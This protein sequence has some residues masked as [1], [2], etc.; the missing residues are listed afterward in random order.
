MTS[1]NKLTIVVGAG[2]SKEFGLP[3]G[4]ELK[5]KISSLLNIEFEDFGRQK[6]GDHEICEALRSVGA[7]RFNGQR[8][9][10]PFLES[11]RHIRDAMPQALSIDNFID[12][13]QGNEGIEIC[14]KLAIS[15]AILDA[16]KQSSLYIDPSNYKN[17]LR[18]DQTEAT[19][20]SPLLKIVTEN[21]RPDGLE[22]RLSGLNFVIFNYDRCVEH[23]LHSWLQNYYRLSDDSASALV[24]GI[25]IYHPYGTVGRLPWQSLKASTIAFGAKPSHSQLLD[26]ARQIKTFTEG[27][28]PDSSDITQIKNLIQT[29]ER[30]M[31]LGFAYHKLNLQLLGSP[32]KLSGQIRHIYGTAAGISSHNCDLIKSELVKT[33]S[34]Q[35]DH[36]HLRNDLFCSGLIEEYSRSLH[37]H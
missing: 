3:T 25:E 7:E 1:A 2:A 31:F 8:S 11:L 30:V 6:S 21:C 19:W 22:E 13:H 34:V 5:S 9:V 32:Y 23:Y 35:R 28:D 26:I 27:T 36:I 12:T 17:K 18:F 16:E 20:L 10:N 4:A 33:A 29:S 14:G 24:N 15:R 37:L